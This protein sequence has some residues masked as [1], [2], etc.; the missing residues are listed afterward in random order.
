MSE[1]VTSGEITRRQAFSWLGLGALSIATVSTVLTGSEAQAE[2][3]TARTGTERRQDRR[4]D[5]TE[6][7]QERRT[8]RTE[9]RQNRR[10]HRSER[11]SDR[12]T[13]SEP[14]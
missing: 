9:R 8:H 6:R 11:R 10:T 14:K 7:R 5:R 3:A 4:T 2:E 13:G 1:K 12:R